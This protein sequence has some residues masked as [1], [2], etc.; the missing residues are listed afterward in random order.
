MAKETSIIYR[1]PFCK[2]EVWF[3][4]VHDLAFHFFKDHLGEALHAYANQQKTRVHKKF[5]K[6]IVKT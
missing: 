3:N 5:E 2:G 1:C 4:Y 6:W